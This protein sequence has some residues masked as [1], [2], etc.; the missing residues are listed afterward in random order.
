M[1]RHDVLFGQFRPELRR[2]SPEALSR[3]QRSARAEYAAMDSSSQSDSPKIEQQSVGTLWRDGKYAVGRVG[4]LDFPDRCAVCNAPVGA[5]REPML[6]V[7]R[8]FFQWWLWWDLRVWTFFHKGAFGQAVGV[9]APLCERH[10]LRR[11]LGAWLIAT[12]VP[13]GSV[14]T[15]H[16]AYVCSPAGAVGC[17][18]ATLAAVCLGLSLRRV[19]SLKRERDGRAW[20]KVGRRFLDSLPTGLLPAL[21]QHAS[22]EHPR[23]ANTA[24]TASVTTGV[25]TTAYRG[26]GPPAWVAGNVWR[27]DD[28][29]VGDPYD[30]ALPDRCVVCNRSCSGQRR[31]VAIKY[32]T[33]AWR[34]RLGRLLW[35]CHL[36]P[37][38]DRVL[39]VALPVCRWHQRRAVA[40]AWLIGGSYLVMYQ[41]VGVIEY[42]IKQLMLH[43]EASYSVLL[44]SVFAPAVL[45]V[46]FW[47]GMAFVLACAGHRCRDVVRVKRLSDDTIWL[48]AGRRFLESIPRAPRSS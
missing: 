5:R 4:D 19:I 24:S 43:G 38:V 17:L 46:L 47:S 40:G 34:R 11:K 16:Y 2:K 15:W 13:V 44:W 37:R 21:E 3:N 31:Q 36:G 30:L 7:H 45:C 8:S 29:I 10:A 22:T 12:S 35:P 1:A 6:L 48:R 27:E 42:A 14:A 23:P 18:A 26:G 41:N 32:C 28:C 9:L 39:P 33:S 25:A 20:F